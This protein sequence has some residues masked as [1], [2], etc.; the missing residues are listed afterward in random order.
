MRRV[1]TICLTTRI[2]DA[3]TTD[4]AIPHGYRHFLTSDYCY[5]R[6]LAHFSSPETKTNMAAA[7]LDDE[8]TRVNKAR[9][10]PIHAPP[11][12][13]RAAG[14]EANIIQCWCFQTLFLC[15]CTA[16]VAMQWEVSVSDAG[17]YCFLSIVV[18]TIK[19]SFIFWFFSV[20]VYKTLIEMNI[21]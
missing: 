12:L 1:L 16:L 10:A 21:E 17:I 9:A 20:I 6:P 2:G 7:S 13:S 19:L 3:E 11:R 14:W 4:N 15:L 5:Q 8:T 18:W